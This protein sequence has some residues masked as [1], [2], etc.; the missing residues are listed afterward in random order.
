MQCVQIL[1]WSFDPWTSEIERTRTRELLL[2]LIDGAVSS[3]A[4]EQKY[5]LLR[6]M[7]QILPGVKIPTVIEERH[8]TFRFL[9]DCDSTTRDFIFDFLL[10]VLLYKRPP[11]LS[12]AALQRSKALVQPRL[13]HQEIRIFPGGASSLL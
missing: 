11:I 13:Q 1:V 8:K 4:E 6:L 9:A 10:S 12:N 2:L 5:S 3:S 7:I